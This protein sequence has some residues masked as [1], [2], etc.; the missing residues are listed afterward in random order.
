MKTFEKGQVVISSIV[1]LMRFIGLKEIDEKK[2]FAFEPLYH[3]Y[4]KIVIMIPQ[5]VPKSIEI[6]SPID[7]KTAKQILKKIETKILAQE[8][9]LKKVPGFRKVAAYDK[10]IFSF[11]I[12]KLAGLVV[13]FYCSQQKN[14]S[15]QLSSTAQEYYNKARKLLIRELAYSLGQS[16]EKIDQ[17][18]Q[19]ILEEHHLLKKK[20]VKKKS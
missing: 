15:K 20:V 18:L 10:I 8:L 5:G 3:N 9:E 16:E 13:Y 12:N 1:G 6:R 17:R 19:K 14:C 4:T 2:F 7:S 11:D